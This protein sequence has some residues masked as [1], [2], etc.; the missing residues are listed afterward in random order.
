VRLISADWVLPVS[1]PPIRDGAVLLDG[2]CIADVGARADLAARYPGAVTEHFGGCVVMPGLVNAHTHLTLTD[3]AGEVPSMPFVEWLPA[4]VSAMKPWTVADHEASGAH[5]ARECLLAGV[6]AVGD[7]AYG[8]AEVVAAASMGLAGVCYWELL[9]M[10]AGFV[11]DELEALRYPSHPELYGPR[12]TCGL[13]PHSPY[14]SGPELLQAVHATAAEKGVPLAIHV[15]ESAA[16]VE[17]LRDGTGPLAAVA[18][19]TAFGFQAPGTSTVRYL[20]DLGVLSGATAVH[21]CHVTAE[22]IELLAAEARGVVTCPRSNRY[23]GNPVPDVTAF[24]AAGIPVGIGTDSA[25]S[26]WDLDLMAEIRT[27]R[28]IHPTI[29]ART[30]IEIVTSQGA[31]AI[32][33][34]D[35]FGTLQRGKQ[36]DLAVFALGDVDEPEEAVVGGAG[37]ANLQ[38]LAVGG[39]WRV[40]DGTWQDG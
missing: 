22:D 19:R 26:N 37:A 34:A 11:P 9:G 24:L 28:E 10:R 14:T 2:G 38:A 13:S 25:A 20:H 7:I 35:Q 23:L 4:L 36:A 3:L 12:V 27:L 16:E 30:L 21:C 32:G 8:A 31:R 39:S 6:T 29:P 17:L 1:R 15:A 33:I 5:G 40:L 18:G